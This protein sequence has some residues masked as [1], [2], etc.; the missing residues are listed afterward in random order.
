[1]DQ[2]ACEM[3]QVWHGRAE[4]LSELG[5]RGNEQ[6]S[7]CLFWPLFAPSLQIPCIF[8]FFR[9]GG[10]H[11]CVS[12]CSDQCCWGKEVTGPE[13]IVYCAYKGSFVCLLYLKNCSRDYIL[14]TV[15][16]LL[17]T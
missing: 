4:G 16:N 17:N 9:D 2:A 15:K 13:R 5:T 14:N 10:S 1:M 12:G 3:Y 7:R 8:L 6:Q 11:C